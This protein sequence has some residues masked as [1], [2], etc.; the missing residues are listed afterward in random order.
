MR[1]KRFAKQKGYK[2][3]VIG[4][5]WANGHFKGVVIGN[6]MLWISD[7]YVHV[8]NLKTNKLKIFTE[9]ERGVQLDKSWSYRSSWYSLNKYFRKFLQGTDIYDAEV[10]DYEASNSGY[11]GAVLLEV[12][13]PTNARIHLLD[14]TIMYGQPIHRIISVSTLT[15][16]KYHII[17]NR[18]KC[19]IPIKTVGIIPKVIDKRVADIFRARYTYARA[20]T[21]DRR[22]I[23]F[24][25]VALTYNKIKL[26]KR[27]TGMSEEQCEEATFDLKQAVYIIPDRYI[28]KVYDIDSIAQIHVKVRNDWVKMFF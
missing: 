16:V 17:H 26:C 20:I 28:Q 13:I 14:S 5:T 10:I 23:Y 12:R 18:S 22:T 2:T 3:K 25:V 7:G 27:L 8:Y 11:S 21:N 9:L 1:F 15:N 6:T 4:L 19:A 24:P